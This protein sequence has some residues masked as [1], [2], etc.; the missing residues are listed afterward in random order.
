MGPSMETGESDGG[1]RQLFESH[2]EEKMKQYTDI[3]VL[4]DRSGSMQAIKGPMETAFNTFVEEHKSIPSSRLTLI[5][6]DD[7]DPQ[8]IVY[9]GV[10]IAYAEKL[11]IRPRGNTPLLDAFCQAIDATG[12]RLANIPE[13]DRPDQVLF[14]VITDGQ[15]NASVKQQRYDVRNRVNHQ[16]SQYKWQFVYLGA[17]QDAIAEAQSYGIPK[18]FA[19]NYK[20][21]TGGTRAMGAALASSTIAYAH[22]VN[23][24]ATAPEFTDTQRKQ[25]EEK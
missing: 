8:E 3:T 14:V 9:Q 12:A 1:W 23:R 20:A 10:P 21:T 24:G 13:S 17:N 5:Q 11:V 6:F 19:M 18:D 22:N 15:E 16:R 7:N 25:A 4:L 2:C